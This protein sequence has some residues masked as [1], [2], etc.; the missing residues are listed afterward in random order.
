MLNNNTK[1]KQYQKDKVG[2]ETGQERENVKKRDRDRDR[3]TGEDG[4]RGEKT[5]KSKEHF[6][7][8]SANNNIWHERKQQQNRNAGNSHVPHF[9]PK[10]VGDK[11]ISG[12]FGHR[13]SM[14][15]IA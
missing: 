13:N 2:E 9:V 8:N 3:E 7:K 4:W 15:V 14:P 11:T 1:S 12:S 5:G 6:G 10:S